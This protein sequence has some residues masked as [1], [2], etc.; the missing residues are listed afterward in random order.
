MTRTFTTFGLLLAAYALVVPQ[1]Q[2]QL[3]AQINFQPATSTAPSGYVADTGLGFDAERGYGWVAPG[4]AVAVDMTTNTRARSGTADGRL[5][6][7]ILMQDSAN[8]DGGVDGSW[9]YAVPNGRYEV[10][11]SVGDNGFG[12]SVHRIEVEGVVAIDNVVL[13]A[14]AFSGNTVT[15][16][17]ADGRLTLDA[18]GGTNTK[19][20]YVDIAPAGSGGDDATPPEVEVLLS[21]STDGSGAYLN[22]ATVTISAADEGGSGLNSVA[23]SL[24]GSPFTAYTG[25]FSVASQGSHTLTA[26]AFD[27]DGNAGTDAVS[28]SVVVPPSNAEIELENLDV[29]PFADRLAFSRIQ[30]PVTG[31]N[32]NA[33]HDEAVLRVHNEGTEDLVITG[34]TIADPSAFELVSPPALPA[35]VVPGGS[36]DVPVRF[37]A[38]VVGSRGG[39]YES[40]LTIESNDTDEPSVVV[41]LGGFWQSQSEGGQEPDVAEIVEVFG[42]GTTIRG[43]GQRLNNRGLV[44]TIGDEVLAPYWKRANPNEPVTVRQLA[45]YHTQGN[46]ASFFWHPQ[47]TQNTTNV[48]THKGSWGQSILPL[49]NSTQ[50]QPGLSAFTPSSEAFGFK[51]DPE[52]SD[53]AINRMKNRDDPDVCKNDSDPANDDQCGHHVRVW[54]VK[55]R[56]GNAVPGQYIVVMDYSGINYDFNDNVYL[57]TNIVPD[58]FVDTD[59]PAVPLALSATGS[60]SG[61]ALD[62]AGGSELDL[63]GYNVLPC[64]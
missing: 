63:A 31:A 44:T 13:S 23:Y 43:P 24:D 1:A 26:R 45:A 52:W 11:V 3:A 53:P 22:A 64:R 56:Q 55:D 9:E 51:I 29:V 50:D 47:G 20:N 40:T 62:W 46:T 58:D 21:G 57:L 36:L 39:V 59:A 27:G 5:G 32:A 16:S 28:F 60:A 48:L 41:E 6:T 17:V 7:M 42:Y 61:I 10:S 54:P 8:R 49:K 34:L 2:A 38:Q 18:T 14:G 15:V 30:N 33:V 25:P 19:L 4:T 37:V 35:T 12:D